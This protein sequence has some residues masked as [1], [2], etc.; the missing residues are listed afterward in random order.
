MKILLSGGT[1]FV[2]K[3]LAKLLIDRG[4]EVMVVTRGSSKQENGITYI[5]WLED[6]KSEI[7][8][9]RGK[10]IE[11]LINL[12]GHPINDGRWTVDKKDKI[13][14]SRLQATER[15][16]EIAAQLAT[17][18]KAFIQGSAIGAYGYQGQISLTENSPVLNNSFPAA[19]CEQWEA[20]FEHANLP[21]TRKVIARIGIVLG[22]NEGALPSLIKPFQIGVGGR[23]ASG[24]Q[25]LS[26]IHEQDAAELLAWCA[27]SDIEGIVN[28]T[29]PNPVQFDTFSKVASSTLHRP[30]WN[31]VPASL[32]RVLFGEMAEF[33]IEGQR[34]APQ[35]AIDHDVPFAFPHLEE[36]LH[37]LLRT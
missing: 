20:L 4:H 36:A 33:L 3:A 31:R 10:S 23:I 12:A 18:P 11:V 1:G 32:L 28:I 25:W 6:S 19:V 5:H 26:W 14:T 8:Y 9:F 17:P 34:V 37:K 29:A 27:T 2:G 15:M 30:N 16:L 7:N 13:L 24:Q 21:D 35:V 22:R